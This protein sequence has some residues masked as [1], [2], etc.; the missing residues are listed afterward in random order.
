MLISKIEKK[1]K[2]KRDLKEEYLNENGLHEEEIE[3][4]DQDVIIDAV[5]NFMEKRRK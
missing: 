3:I 5:K 2:K 1:K 4:E